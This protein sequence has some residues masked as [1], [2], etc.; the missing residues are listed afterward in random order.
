LNAEPDNNRSSCRKRKIAESGDYNLSGD[1][2]IEA[3]HFANQ[4]WPMVELGK[5]VISKKEHQLQKQKSL[6]AMFR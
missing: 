6:T 2:Y 3:I 5:F 1:R 4:K